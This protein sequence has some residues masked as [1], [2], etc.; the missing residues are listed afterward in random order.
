MVTTKQEVGGSGSNNRPNKRLE[1][2]LEL[3]NFQGSRMDHIEQEVWVA[4]KDRDCRNVEVNQGDGG[5]GVGPRGW[6]KDE[7]GKDLKK[8]VPPKFDG[9]AIGIGAK[10]WI[11]EMEKNF[12]L[13]NLSN[14]TKAAWATYQLS[15]EV[16]TW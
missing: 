2:I 11:I 10:A 13:R 4:C 9:K 5:L 14:Q 8:V 6:I 3:L 12:G 15:G 1:K 7:L 16:A